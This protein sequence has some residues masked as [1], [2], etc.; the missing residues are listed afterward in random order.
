[1]KAEEGEGQQVLGVLET[2][3]DNTTDWGE[4]VFRSQR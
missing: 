3:N 2:G 4:G 1:M